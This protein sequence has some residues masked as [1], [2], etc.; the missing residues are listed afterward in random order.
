MDLVLVHLTKAELKYVGMRH[1]AQY[2]TEGGP[3]QMQEQRADSWDSQE[4]VGE[5]NYTLNQSQCGGFW[6]L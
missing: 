1:G 4:Q 3:Q 5:Y 6:F 2:V